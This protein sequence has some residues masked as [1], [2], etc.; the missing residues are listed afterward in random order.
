MDE[1]LRNLERLAA[2]GDDAA[3]ALYYRS[4][5]RSGRF[6]GIEIQAR[7]GDQDALAA[8]LTGLHYLDELNI[9]SLW[10]YP[11]FSRPYGEVGNRFLF[12]YPLP[13]RPGLNLQ[14][15]T[16]FVTL[17]RGGLSYPFIGAWVVSE[18]TINAADKVAHDYHSY[19]LSQIDETLEHNTEAEIEARAELIRFFV[20]RAESLLLITKNGT[21][22]P[23]PEEDLDRHRL[24]S[25]QPIYRYLHSRHESEPQ[26]RIPNWPA[27]PRVGM[28]MVSRFPER[29]ST[30]PN[31]RYAVVV[32][33][34]TGRAFSINSA[35]NLLEPELQQDVVLDALRHHSS[36]NL[37]T[38]YHSKPEWA[39]GMPSEDFNTYFVTE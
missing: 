22:F 30:P 13:F 33:K 29:L 38:A 16:S 4:L 10:A 11:F 20:V 35:Y 3:I 14:D 28:H 25:Q 18:Q 12:D 32:H 1:T 27:L 26:P 17:N 34:A 24:K 21:R 23:R 7:L 39:E 2:S 36:A 37:S 6:D 9:N 5:Q 8:F 31:S 19:H 15:I